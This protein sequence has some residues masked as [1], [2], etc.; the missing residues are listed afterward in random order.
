MVAFRRHKS[1]RDY[2]VHAK[3]RATS[4]EDKPKGTV[5]CSD[6]RTLS[7]LRRSENR[8]QFYVKKNKTKQE[9]DTLLISI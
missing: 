4:E 5:K 9:R 3:L 7:G 1:L 8:R 2:L 6:R